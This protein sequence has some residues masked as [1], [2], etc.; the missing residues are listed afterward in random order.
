MP[1]SPQQQKPP[2]IA[3]QLLSIVLSFVL[4]LIGWFLLF[5]ILLLP[6]WVYWFGALIISG[7]IVWLGYSTQ[8]FHIFYKRV[9]SFI[10]PKTPSESSDALEEPIEI[11]KISYTIKDPEDNNEALDAFLDKP[12]PYSRNNQETQF[13][14]SEYDPETGASPSEMIEH[15]V[16]D[17]VMIFEEKF[18]GEIS[19]EAKI[20]RG[21]LTFTLTF[22]AGSYAAISQYK[23]FIESVSLVRDQLRRAITSISNAYPGS[24]RLRIIQDIDITPKSKIAATRHSSREPATNDQKSYSPFSVTNTFSPQSNEQPVNV[25]VPL[26]VNRRN[27]CASWIVTF[28]LIAF[29]LTVIFL[30]FNEPTTRKTIVDNIIQN[31]SDLLIE[32][33]HYLQNLGLNFKSYYYTGP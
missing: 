30:L 19:V 12:L 33:G 25:N 18:H 15:L 6:I 32:L 10:T 4:M 29:I 1:K 13:T 17:I 5:W 9:R 2:T 3:F 7:F 26:P 8:L 16:L 11:A 14:Q 20:N 21:S 31:L 27:G 23:D 22:I 24:K 28:F